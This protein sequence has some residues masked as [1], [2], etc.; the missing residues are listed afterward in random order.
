MEKNLH[1]GEGIAT[2]LGSEYTPFHFLCK[3]LTVEALDRS[4]IDVLAQFENALKFREALESINPGV[5]SFLRGEISVAL[6]AIKSILFFVSH[7]KSA[8]STNQAELFD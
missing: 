8:S 3:A 4:N 7:D 2:A 6:C 1:I 5:K